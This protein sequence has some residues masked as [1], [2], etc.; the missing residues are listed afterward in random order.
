[1]LRSADRQ[2]R[3]VLATAS[4]PRAW[5]RGAEGAGCCV[6]PSLADAATRAVRRAGARHTSRFA[7]VRA[8]RARL[9][10]LWP[11]E[12]RQRLAC[13]AF[14]CLAFCARFGKKDTHAGSRVCCR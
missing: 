11:V 13:V 1:M 8:R 7:L 14:R 12:L 10:L 3:G 4:T 9:V 5:L 6:L 2:A